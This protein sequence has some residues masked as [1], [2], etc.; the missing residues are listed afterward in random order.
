MR[1][2]TLPAR[3]G[4]NGAIE[5][6]VPP[7]TDWVGRDNPDGTYLIATSAT[8]SP[9]AGRIEHPPRQALENACA[10][11]GLHYREVAEVWYVSG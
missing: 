1:Y 8:L 9:A 3:M 2:Y 4:T 10:A 7:G 5:A 6:D 11:R